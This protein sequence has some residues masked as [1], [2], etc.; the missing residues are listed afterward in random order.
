L[1]DAIVSIGSTTST[2]LSGADLS[3]ARFE[4]IHIYLDEGIGS[5]TLRMM[6]AYVDGHPDP[7]SERADNST[8]VRIRPGDTVTLDREAF[9]K[10]AKRF[11]GANV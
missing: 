3:D 10:L 7:D 9:R 6:Q 5:S 11:Y 8:E 4:S 2:E 1:D